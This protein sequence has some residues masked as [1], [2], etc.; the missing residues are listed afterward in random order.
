MDAEVEFHLRSRIDAL[1]S[2]GKSRTEAREQALRE[3]GDVAEARR[4]LA[5]IDR[6]GASRLKLTAL[7]DAASQDVR[8]ALRGL[9]R[10]PGFA[11]TVIAT[12]AIG[13]GANA[14]MFGIVDR[15]MLQPPPHV[16]H[17]ES[18]RRMYH[19]A[20]FPGAGE[21]T[22]DS[23]SYPDYLAL[24]DARDLFDGVAAYWPTTF[25]MGRGAD[26]KEVRSLVVSPSFFAVTGV[27]PWMGRF[28][29]E[30]ENRPPVSEAVAV[31]SFS[32]WSRDFGGDPSVI[33]RTIDFAGRRASVVGIAPPGFRGVDIEPVD[34][35]T[36]FATVAARRVTPDWDTARDWSWLRV[37]TRMRPGVT[38][39]KAGAA[40]TLLYRQ[41]HTRDAMDSGT[42]VLVSSVLPGRTPNA[43]TEYR[44]SVWL[45]GV[46]AIMLVIATA[47]VA[48]LL[49]ARAARRRRE[50]AV[51]RSLGVTRGRLA[52]QLIIEG[53]VLSLLGV[54][55]ALALTQ[56]GG[57]LLRSLLLPDF[58][59]D[60][61]IIDARVFGVAL[62]VAV[63]CG[64]VTSLAPML[65]RTDSDLTTDLRS[66]AREGG[67]RKSRLRIALVI[68]QASLSVV[69]LIGASLFMR[70]LRNAQQTDLGYDAKRVLVASWDL[71]SVG[72]KAP[73]AA[74]LYQRARDRVAALPE[75][76]TASLTG[77]V[78]FQSSW[79]TTLRV[80]GWDSLPRFADGG[81]YVNA[82]DSTYLETMGMRVIR[83]RRFGAG[84][85]EGAPRVAL[86]NESMA[87]RLFPSGNSIGKCLYIGDSVPPC[88]SIVGVVNDT[89]RQE[90]R[91]AQSMLYYVP[92][93]QRLGGGPS[94]R[95]LLVRAAVD[96]ELAGR[97]VAK[98]MQQLQSDLPFVE[99][100]T[101]QDLVEPKI[102]PW[103]LGAWLFLTFGGLAAIVAMIGLYSVV[104]F[105][106]AQRTHEFGIRLALG[107]RASGVAKLVLKDGLLT[108]GTGLIL[109]VAVAL[110]AAPW[111]EPL[112][113]DV[114]A[115]DPWLLSISAGV[116]LIVAG[117]ASL[118]PALRAS[119]IAPVDALRQD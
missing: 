100:R 34:V 96:P 3:F 113:L 31:L 37:I 116:L 53:L 88:A 52:S 57:S 82:V 114:S 65:P 62:L 58:A 108:A 43:P 45:L 9:Q 16:L 103:R 2:E 17:A 6:R 1:T 8:Y 72:I 23:R 118:I 54:V 33:G 105:D 11:A 76:A 77:T 50:I 20:I 35:F 84:D 13:I 117:I 97:A 85:V 102:R 75:V 111:L 5:K 40:S 69:L 83:G 107:A 29:S 80:E 48:N 93:A 68:T 39:A 67:Y 56:W 49:L 32:F 24:R 110:G 91:G 89:H 99:V 95:A 19:R 64:L 87:R 70:S 59:P 46:A 30:E 26:A 55:A 63:T 44:V 119:H 101:L 90:L 15:L 10:S 106:A 104:T 86:V 98:A 36:P 79:G 112:L 18:L 47:N 51:R 4:E 109:G 21:F 71:G 7:L 61:A 73:Q 28:F 115:R 38:D 14:T 12:L 41:I 27:R 74:A 22:Q 42:T 92:Q 78:P 25:S 60:D 81:P 66:G 94:M